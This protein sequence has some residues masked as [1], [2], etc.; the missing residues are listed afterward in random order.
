MTVVEQ[1]AAQLDYCKKRFVPNPPFWT[2][3]GSIFV[4]IGI[5]AGTGATYYSDTGRIRESQAATAATVKEIGENHRELAGE[6]RELRNTMIQKQ[7]AVI[8]EL[9]YLRSDL[10]GR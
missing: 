10:K 5:V 1:I 4:L 2:I 9:R 6:V 3:M 7:D 8:K